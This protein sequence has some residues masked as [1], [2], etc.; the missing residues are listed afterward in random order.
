MYQKTIFMCVHLKWFPTNLIQYKSADRMNICC[1][2][3]DIDKKS[4]VK[5]I[6]LASWKS[7]NRRKKKSRDQEQTMRRYHS[8]GM[9]SFKRAKKIKHLS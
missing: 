4:E 2:W 3:R 8:V 1:W 7:Q 6:S 9:K 5:Q